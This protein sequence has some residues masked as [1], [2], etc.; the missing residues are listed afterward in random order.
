M[1]YAFYAVLL[2]K[3]TF[4]KWNRLFL[5]VYS[6]ACFI[7]PFINLDHWLQN[8]TV[9]PVV[10]EAIPPFNNFVPATANFFNAQL[11]ILAFLLTGSLICLVKLIIQFISYRKLTRSAVLLH[12]AGNIRIYS[13]NTGCSFTLGN[14]IYIDT[15]AHSGDEL[16][17]VLQHEMIHV[18]QRHWIDLIIGEI[19]IIFNW[20]NPFAWYMRRAIRQNLEF[21]AD[22]QVLQ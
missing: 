15:A 19:L 8:T 21:I 7:I 22:Q 20:F 17:K 9:T 5:L 3:L 12:N 11:I 4:Y 14:N 1:I 13:S 10:L 6:T 2:R 16:E 18:K